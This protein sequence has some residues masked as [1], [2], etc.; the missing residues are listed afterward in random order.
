[1]NDLDIGVIVFY[2]FESFTHE[3]ALPQNCYN[4]HTKYNVLYPKY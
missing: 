4:Y 3:H 2:C 1:M